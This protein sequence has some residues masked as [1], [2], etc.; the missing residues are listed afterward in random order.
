MLRVEAIK[1]VCMWGYYVGVG[2]IFELYG[3]VFSV[4]GGCKWGNISVW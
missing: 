1:W 2:G 4:G 3:H